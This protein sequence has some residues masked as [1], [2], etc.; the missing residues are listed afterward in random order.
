M[1]SSEQRLQRRDYVILA[2]FCLVLFGHAL[3]VGGPLTMHE[4]VLSQTSRAMYLEPDWIVPR[5]GEAP[6][7]ERPPL[8]QWITVAIANVVGHC[9]AEWVVRLGPILAGTVTVL[10]TGWLAGAWFG[11][12][13]GLLAGLILASM[14]QFLRY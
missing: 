3:F 1:V 7:L 4:G 14:Y 5:M 11:R 6:W 9:D 8:P 12:A 13:I 10:I 2:I